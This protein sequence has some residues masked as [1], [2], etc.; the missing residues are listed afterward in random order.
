MTIGVNSDDEKPSNDLPQ[1][2]DLPLID[3]K[4]FL[5]Q[6]STSV[7][8]VTRLVDEACRKHGFFLVVNHGIDPDLIREVHEGTDLFFGMSMS[9]KLRTK[10]EPDTMF[11]YDTSLKGQLASNLRWLETLTFPFISNENKSSDMQVEDYFLRTTGEEYRHF[12]ALMQKYCEA[13][14][15]LSLDIMELLSVSLGINKNYFREFFK[16]N[17]SIMRLNYYPP[18]QNPHQ[19][20]GIAP[21]C[22]PNSLTILHQDDT[23]GLQVLIDEKWLTIQPNRDAFVINIGDTFMALS[24]GI[25]KSCVHRAAVNSTTSRKSVTFFLNPNKERIIVPPSDLVNMENPRL[26][27]DFTWS[28]FLDFTQKNYRI[29]MKMLDAFSNL[30]GE[31]SVDAFKVEDENKEDAN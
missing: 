31:N 20:L 30:L 21:H 5:S 4:E 24:N 29:H 28:K 13:M 18:C 19:K 3:M 9:E 8:N 16:E 27:P 23:G 10:R 11:G 25:Y 26:Y 12:G 6:D 15:A 2:L 17:D 22:D 7:F 1:L 14:N